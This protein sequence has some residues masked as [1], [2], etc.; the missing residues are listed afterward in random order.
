MTPPRNLYIF[1]LCAHI[2]GTKPSMPKFKILVCYHKKDP[3]F[4]NEVLVPIHAGRACAL[5]ASKDGKLPKEDFDW[6]YS[7]MIGDD[8]GGG[9]NN[10]SHLNRS[11]NEWS[12]IYWAYKNYEKL[13]NPDYIGLMHYRR[14]FDFSD[15][16]ITSKKY[17]LDA[18]GLRKKYLEQIFSQYD[19]VCRKLQFPADSPNLRGLEQMSEVMLLSPEYH[20]ILYKGYK[21]FLEDRVLHHTNMFIMKKDDFFAYCEEIIP[22]MRDLLTRDRNELFEIYFKY[23]KQYEDK[24]SYEKAYA[25]YKN[26]DYYSPRFLGHVLERASSFY[27]THLI[28]RYGKDALCAQMFLVRSPKKIIVNRKHKNHRILKII[29]KC[30]V[31]KK[32][33]KKLKR[34][35][36]RFFRDSKN[37]IIKFLGK[38][39]D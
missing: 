23:R 9:Q 3:L 11:I 7:H 31:D 25:A 20:P 22:L 4:K 27:F 21:K 2:S 30:L 33:Y 17:L 5:E 13:G 6:L 15:V 10:V 32:R 16:V 26:S 12:A 28:E 38:Y 14:L 29:I 8:T 24:E 1:K 36:K 34:N 19:F 37:S 35:P 18:L 39:Y